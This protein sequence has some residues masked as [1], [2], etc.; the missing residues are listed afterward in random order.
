MFKILTLG[1]GSP[2]AEEAAITAAI[3]NKIDANFIVNYFGMIIF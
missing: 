3:S 2:A 1:R